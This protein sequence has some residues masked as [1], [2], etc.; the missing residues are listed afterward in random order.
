[1]AVT[2]LIVAQGVDRAFQSIEFEYYDTITETVASNWAT[3]GIRG[4][5]E[6]H[7]YYDNTGSAIWNFNLVFVAG[8]GQGSSLTTEDIK[9]RANFIKALQYPRYGNP[10]LVSPPPRVH[11]RI[12]KLLDARGIVKNPNF[13]YNSPYDNETGLPLKID[14]TF[15]FEITHNRALGFKDVLDSLPAR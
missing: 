11:I 9:R 3:I 4:R 2:G 12:G 5:S 14:V 15:T 7:Q 13:I 6:P 1:M 10:P 8:A